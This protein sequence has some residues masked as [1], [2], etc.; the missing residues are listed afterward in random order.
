[1]RLHA[2]K[3]R[4]C[5]TPTPRARTDGCAHEGGPRPPDP[6]PPRSDGSG[7]AARRAVVSRDLLNSRVPVDDGY[8]TAEAAVV[9]PSLLVVLAMAVWVLSCV[10]AQLRCVDA[11]RTGAR[12]AARGDPPPVAIAAARRVAPSGAT[13]V[14]RREDRQ[15]RVDVTVALR[16]FGHAL[17]VLPA[18][19]LRAVA[20]AE[21]EDLAP[22]PGP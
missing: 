10:A 17:R 7:P 5:R 9:L 14:V 3:D 1:M 8:A 22:G 6:P 12:D 2:R 21:R 4:S 13:V 15:V 19:Q 16:P 11:A 20:T 18:V